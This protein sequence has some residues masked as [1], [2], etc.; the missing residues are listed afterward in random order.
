MEWCP[1]NSRRVG[2]VFSQTIWIKLST[3]SNLKQIK[4]NR[5]CDVGLLRRWE[6]PRIW[7]FAQFQLF[8]LMK[9]EGKRM[10]QSMKSEESKDPEL[11]E[12][13]PLNRSFDEEE[14]KTVI[15]E[16]GWQGREEL[17]EIW[18]WKEAQISHWNSKGKPST[19]IF[20]F[21]VFWRLIEFCS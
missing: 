19:I 5:S 13:L 14:Q 4:E 8:E 15:L 12:F 1:R 21:L 18:P 17:G 16:K 9:Q 11:K 20:R 6:S 2:Y 7:N 10:K 3:E